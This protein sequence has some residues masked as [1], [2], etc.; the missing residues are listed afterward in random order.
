MKKILLIS[1]IPG[2]MEALMEYYLNNIENKNMYNIELLELYKF[3]NNK[4]KGKFLKIKFLFKKYDLVIA[5]YPTELLKIGEKSIY[6]DHGSGLK[7]MPGKNEMNKI[8]VK[9]VSNIISKCDI[10]VIQSKREENILYSWLPYIDKNNI[11]FKCLGQ[12]RNDKLFN[13]NL[14]E[15]LKEEIYLKYSIPKKDKLILLAPTWRGYKLDCNIFNE[16]NIEILNEF[17]E[18]NNYTL[19]YR[20]HYLEDIFNRNLFNKTKFII[21]DSSKEKNTQNIL[22]ASDILITDYSGILTEFLALN[23]PVLFLDIDVEKYKNI[24]G[25]AIDYYNE[26]HTPGPK[27]NNVNQI[28]EYLNELKNNNDIYEEKRKKSISYYYE[29][30]DG[31]SSKRIW[32][33]INYLL[34]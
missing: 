32:R 30:Y 25:L 17:L 27:I 13:E 28:I 20:P 3:Y 24:R 9:R 34:K 4:I 19:I 18:K 29:N 22:A 8:K 10:F 1:V 6:M 7:L 14:K 11:N 23:R 21:L 16:I 5:D 33:Y 2:N 26:L 12:P 15:N 31:K